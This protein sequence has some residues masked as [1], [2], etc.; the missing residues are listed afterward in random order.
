MTQSISFL[1]DDP[2][3]IGGLLTDAHRSV[4][5]MQQGVPIPE[6]LPGL[7]LGAARRGLAVFAGTGQLELPA[8]YRLA[9]RELGL[10]IGL[11]AV[12]RLQSRLEKAESPPAGTI[13]WAEKIQAVR[14]FASLTHQIESCWLDHGAQ[15]LETWMEH[16]DINAVMLATSLSPAGYLES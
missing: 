14:A 13:P 4:R 9:F 16:Q 3:G 2:L 7:L 1:T 15:R 5:L 11:H 6:N 12:D 10:S 8:Q